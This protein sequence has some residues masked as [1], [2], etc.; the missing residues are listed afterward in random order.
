MKTLFIG[1]NSIHLVLVD[2]TNSY[3]SELLR[4]TKPVEGTL[5][6]TFEQHNGRGQR[7]NLWECQPNKN[8]TFSLILYPAFLPAEKQFLLTKITSLAAAD[9]MAEILSLSDKTG[10]IRIKWPNDIYIGN[11]KITGILI[12][13]SLRE[14]S[15]QSAIVGIGININQLIFNTTATATSLALL[16]NKEYDLMQCIERLCELLEAR[17]LQLKAGKFETINSE[18]T[19]RLYQLNDWKDYVCDK[20]TFKG[21]IIGVSALGRLQI[22]LESKETKEF[23]L[24]EIVF[25]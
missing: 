15:V 3:A 2:S 16:T 9:L 13:T 5:I 8:A 17:Y 4:Q 11:K 23:T 18:Y 21:K 1:Q 12:E 14:N 20:Q 22:E 25:L 6:Y 24:K 19:Q 7:G 10:D